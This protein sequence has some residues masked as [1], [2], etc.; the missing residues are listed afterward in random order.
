MHDQYLAQETDRYWCRI[1]IE[2]YFNNLFDAARRLSEGLEKNHLGFELKNR[3][4]FQGEQEE[5]HKNSG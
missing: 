2:Q 4:Y 5:V 3:H 1:V